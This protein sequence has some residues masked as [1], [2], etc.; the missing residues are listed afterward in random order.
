MTLYPTLTCSL[1]ADSGSNASR[2]LRNHGMLPASVF[3]HGDPMRLV[4]NRHDFGVI[5]HES[6][7]GSQL[8]HLSID[9]TESVLVLVKAVQRDTLKKMPLHVDFQRISLQEK[10]QATV[11]VVLEGESPGVKEGGMLEIIMHA[12]HLRCAAGVVPDQV[13]YDIS[14]MKMGD[15]LEAGA[16]VL[17]EGCELLDRPEECVALVRQPR[18]A[19]TAA[20]AATE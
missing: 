16:F 14:T 18:T 11:A 8:I 10:L 20:G 1:R 5:E 7:S 15:T 17:P 4:L 12:L 9:G 3:G 6:H 19:P 13:T 2:K